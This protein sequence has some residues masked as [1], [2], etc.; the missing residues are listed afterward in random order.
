[1]QI[2]SSCLSAGSAHSGVKVAPVLAPTTARPCLSLQRRTTSFLSLRIH[3]LPSSPPHLRGAD[4]A[5]AGS[6]RERPTIETFLLLL[7]RHLHSLAA[8]YES[9]DDA[10]FRCWPGTIYTCGERDEKKKRNP[11]YNGNGI[12]LQVV[13]R[14]PSSTP[15][16]A[17]Q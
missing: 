4:F 10:S 14:P 2:R 16:L 3:P 15:S 17:L 7:L 5:R 9:S 1:M 6:P 13:E 11:S 12:L 8:I